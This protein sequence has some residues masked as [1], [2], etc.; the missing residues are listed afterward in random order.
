M[1]EKTDLLY[2][3][4]GRNAPC[5]CGSGK[6]YK[7]C[8][9]PGHR[10][11]AQWNQ[12]KEEVET[13]SDRYFA[14]QDYI[15]HAGYPLLYFDLFLIEL[16]NITGGTLHTYQKLPAPVMKKVLA[17]MLKEAKSFYLTCCNCEHEC[18]KKPLE[19]VSFKSLTDK[20]LRIEEFPQPMQKKIKLNFFYFEFLNSLISSLLRELKVILPEEEAD[21]IAYTVHTSIFVYLA[22]E[23]WDNC[24]NRC[25]K[26]HDQNA[27]C[28]FCSFGEHRLSCPREGETTYIQIMASEEDMAH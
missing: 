27:Y 25:I 13:I 4:V 18:L 9:L 19:R 21:D 10:A 2:R 28:R 3:Q 7:K 11:E 6:K 15:K 5:P 17:K 23:C 14:V 22:E 26:Q 1:D 16:L 12:G 24:S 20:G 8:C